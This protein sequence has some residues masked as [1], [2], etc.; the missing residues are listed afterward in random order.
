MALN[1][2]KSAALIC[3]LAL[4]PMTHSVWAFPD[5]PVVLVVPFTA[6]SGSDIVA[7]ILAPKLSEI[8]KQPVIV[9]NKPGASGNLGTA[10]VAQA[11]ADGHVLLMAINT[12]TMTPAVYAKLPYDPSRDFEPIGKLTEA[13][14][15][16][17]VNPQ[18]KAKDLAELI[19]ISKVKPDDM[20]Y[21]TP[22]N[23]TPHHLAMELLKQS[24]GLQATHVPYKGLQGALTDLMGGQVQMMF[25]TVHSL[26][27]H[28]QAGRLRWLAS[29]GTAQPAGAMDAP[30]F[31]EQGVTAMDVVD[32]WYGVLAPART[33]AAL[34][35]R[36]NKDFATVLSQSD[37]QLALTQQGMK[38][39]ISTPAQLTQ[40]IKSDL[41]R[42]R[43]V[44][45]DAGIVAD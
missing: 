43:K 3:L 23:G 25:A 17:A 27:P 42:W 31:R 29:T 12:F 15:A 2:F 6:S 20:Y 11:P 40:L 33:P 22:G 13:G 32:A 44:V 8:W 5:R 37:V 45:A 4:G 19:A 30:T 41:L 36:L 14:Y 10:F 34:V 9:D 35:Q 21:A 26:R 18:I 28:V 16:L 1:W 38:V 24:T 39:S 7:R